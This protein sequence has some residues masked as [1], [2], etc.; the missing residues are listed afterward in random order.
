[1]TWI[2]WM[3]IW[4]FRGSLILFYLVLCICL[5][6]RRRISFY[7]SLMLFRRLKLDVSRP[8]K[9][10]IVFWLGNEC[11]YLRC[12]L[13]FVPLQLV[14]I[15]L[16]QAKVEHIRGS[17]LLFYASATCFCICDFWVGGILQD[18]E[19]NKLAYFRCIGN[20]VKMAIFLTPFSDRA[21]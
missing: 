13:S 2:C 11:S 17:K 1:M 19:A 15:W 16:L 6:S 10:F 12:V 8:C 4:S 7:R 9:M 18:F 20:F 5:N 3:V 14:Y 21:D